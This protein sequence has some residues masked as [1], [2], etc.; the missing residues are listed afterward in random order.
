[1]RARIARGMTMARFE[2]KSCLKLGATVGWVGHGPQEVDVS[3]RA[4]TA[5]G[6]TIVFVATEFEWGVDVEMMLFA[7][8]EGDGTTAVE[9]A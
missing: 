8:S 7:A 4:N 2:A 9:T 5:S 6:M 3:S 1:M